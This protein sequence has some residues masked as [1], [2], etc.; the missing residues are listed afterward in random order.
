MGAMTAEAP[1]PMLPVHGRPMF[2]HIL[3]RL[4]TAGVERFFVVVGYQREMIENHFRDWPLPIEFRVQDPVDGTGSAARL[5]REFAGGEPFLLT[6]GDILCGPA[7][8]T[9]CGSVLLDHPG[10]VAVLGVRDVDDP[11]RG[12][13]VY[14][15]DGRV[16]KVIEKPPPGT[17]TTRWNSAGLYA[18]RPAAFDYLDRLRPSSRGEYELTSIFEMMLQD[19][20]EVRIAPVEGK[21]WDVG[22][23][24]DLEAANAG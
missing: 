8:Y 11:W 4:E 17:S 16:Y 7:V 19:H 5:A 2:E 20:L 13:A 24:D 22:V 6:F 10:T 12:A 1:K 23:P 3:R 21:W 14:E 9:R 15:R 18:M